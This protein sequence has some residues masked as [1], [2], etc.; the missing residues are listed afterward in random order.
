M[1]NSTPCDSQNSTRGAAPL[2][3]LRAAR[4]CPD[5]GGQRCG[6]PG[7]RR[8]RGQ[9]VFLR[10]RCEHTREATRQDKEG[11]QKVSL[12]VRGRAGSKQCRTGPAL[13]LLRLLHSGH[14]RLAK[15]KKTVPDA[16]PRALSLPR[17]TPR[18]AVTPCTE[19]GERRRHEARRCG[20]SPPRTFANSRSTSAPSL[21]PSISSLL[22]S[23][24]TLPP[25]RST[26][27][28]Q[29]VHTHHSSRH[30]APTFTP[31]LS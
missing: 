5:G 7:G 17:T 21:H 25:A 30:Q 10:R 11:G 8:G 22:P 18:R 14:R 9:H 31:S 4:P 19:P 23:S 20:S 29:S 12:L 28:T 24:P 13:S 26:T 6:A 3:T 15:K 27:H 2:L 16:L 1:T